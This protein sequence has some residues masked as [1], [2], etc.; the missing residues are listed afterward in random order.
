MPRVQN[1]LITLLS[2]D[3]LLTSAQVQNLHTTP[4]QL[5]PA[6]GAGFAIVMVEFVIVLGIGS[7]VFA[8]QGGDTLT[9]PYTGT[10]GLTGTATISTLVS[11]T[12]NTMRSV[13]GTPLAN[14]AFGVST[15][16]D[17]QA[18]NLVA[19]ANYNAG[20]IVSSTVGA[21]GSGYAV[22]DTGSI[23][24][25]IGDALYIITS[26]GAGG[27]VTGYTLTAAGTKYVVANGVATADGGAQPGVGTGFTV[28]ISAVNAGN[29][30]IRALPYYAIVP[31]P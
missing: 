2:T 10:S 26:V 27:A 6:P 16:I 14:A 9:T 22:N 31:V 8:T 5:I 23:S 11:R 17:N 7:V 19:A 20:A 29:G 3:T 15:G 13:V 12:V 28:N 1:P 25:G 4:V 21:G 30:T 24:A 18:I